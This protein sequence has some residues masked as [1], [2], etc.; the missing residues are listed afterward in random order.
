MM[1]IRSPRM[2]RS[3]PIT[4]VPV[5]A[6]ADFSNGDGEERAACA[7]VPNGVGPSLGWGRLFLGSVLNT[8][9]PPARRLGAYCMVRLGAFPAG[10]I[11]THIR[12]E[13]LSRRSR[14]RGS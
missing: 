8:S 2:V 9:S 4:D 10:W 3:V 1:V 14:A 12:G 7:A 5:G 13:F 6:D 11:C